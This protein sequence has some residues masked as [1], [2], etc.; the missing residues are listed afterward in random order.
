MAE[1][2]EGLLSKLVKKALMSTASAA[3]SKLG[4]K[5]ATY[6]LDLF[7]LSGMG[8]GDVQE[9]LDLISEQVKQT[10]SKVSEL[11]DEVKWKDATDSF[12]GICAAITTHTKR[13]HDL[14]AITDNT[15]RDAQITKYVTTA[16]PPINGMDTNLTLIDNRIMGQGDG[17]TGVKG[18]PLIKSHIETHWASIWDAS[19]EKTYANIEAVY[20]QCV[21]MQ[22]LATT[23]LV[24]Y[25]KA[26]DQ[27]ELADAAPG[28]LEKRLAAQYSVMLKSIPDFVALSSLSAP[29]VKLAFSNFQIAPKYV[30]IDNGCLSPSSKATSSVWNLYRTAATPPTYL[31]SLAGAMFAVEKVESVVIGAMPFPGGGGMVSEN[32]HYLYMSP[33]SFGFPLIFTIEA[34]DQPNLLRFVNSDGRTLGYIS[35]GDTG[36]LFELTGTTAT[37]TNGLATLA[38]FTKVPS[39]PQPTLSA[40][41]RAYSNTPQG[42]GRFKPS[43]RV[44]YRV[45]SVNR[46][47]ESDKGDWLLAPKSEDSQDNDFYFG[48]HD[49]YFPQ[50]QLHDSEGRTEAYRVF[51]QFHGGAEEEVTA[52]G[53]F[54][55]DPQSG[56]PVIFDDFTP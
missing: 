15:K 31:L 20:L 55:G 10:D 38:N 14:L 44:R 52:G 7:G 27:N 39:A 34:T 56:K 9:T 46:F 32:A 3:G 51:R 6:V 54:T 28:D 25:W 18:E 11:M 26:T 45:I 37:A 53:T 2:T 17:I 49:F 47:G 24:T 50:I 16:N 23:L 30:D 43:F 13:L 29:F 21:Q 5:A 36:Y 35:R 19:P 12:D 22:R 42:E 48:H 1:A 8:L 4:S 40:W 41:S 33:I